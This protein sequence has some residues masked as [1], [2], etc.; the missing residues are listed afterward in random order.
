MEFFKRAF[1][2]SSLNLYPLGDWHFGSP[3]SD[4]KFI[5]M[6]VKHI[7]ADPIGYWVGMGDLMENALISTPGDI[8]G[9]TMPPTDQMDHIVGLLKPIEKKGL[10]MISG[11]HEQRTMKLAGIIP[12]QYMSAMLHIPYLGYSAMAMLQ[13]DRAH[14]S[15]RSFSAYFHHNYG[16]GSKSGA[17]VGAAEKL[18]LI[19]P[20]V[21]AIFSAHVHLTSRVA[22]KWFE[23]GELHAIERLGYDYQTGSALTWN[24]S[25]AEQKGMGPSV[26]EHICVTFNGGKSGTNMK[27]QGY[28]VL[29]EGN[30]S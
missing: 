19:A 15:F 30:L 4:E 16:G 29:N 24:K 22:H 3:Q 28:G 18:R 9:Q 5:K 2:L 27:S 17:K 14:R 12:E 23:P 20:T 8:Y 6:V 7:A 25:Y 21:D 26:V 11:N 1:P 10:F 13:L